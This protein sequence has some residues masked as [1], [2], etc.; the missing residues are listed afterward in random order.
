MQGY[1]FSGLSGFSRFSGF[2]RFSGFRRFGEFSGFSGWVRKKCPYGRCCW[3]VIVWVARSQI[4]EFFDL[5]EVPEPVPIWVPSFGSD[6]GLL[7]LDAGSR[8]RF[9]GTGTN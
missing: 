5:V 1:R 9:L 8:Y 3:Q 6:T 7:D 2:N 4:F